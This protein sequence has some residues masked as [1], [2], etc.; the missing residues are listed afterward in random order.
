MLMP[1]TTE[2]VSQIIAYCNQRSLAVV[3]QGG[4]TG[5]CGGS[6]PIHDEI[7]LNLSQMNKI[8]FYDE[9]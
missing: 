8:L 4:K 9:Y 1:H 6:T 5:L 2:Q 3:P 7:I